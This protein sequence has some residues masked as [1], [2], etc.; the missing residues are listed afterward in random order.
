MAVGGEEDRWFTNPAKEGNGKEKKKKKEKRK[1][2]KNMHV[3][4]AQI[5]Q[6]KSIQ[7]NSYSL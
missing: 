5:D 7:S 3:T 4:R 2:T 6:I 1:E